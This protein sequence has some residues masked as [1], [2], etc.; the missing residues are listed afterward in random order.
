MRI[1]HFCWELKKKL[2]KKYFKNEQQVKQ[3]WQLMNT[4]NLLCRTIQ[5]QQCDNLYWGCMWAEGIQLKSKEKDATSIYNELKLKKWL[6]GK[7]CC[8]WVEQNVTY[9]CSDALSTLRDLGEGIIDGGDIGDDWL[10][11][12]RWNINIW[13]E[14]RQEIRK[15]ELKTWW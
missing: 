10:L 2:I 15:R 3:H 14:R 6:H 9:V 7:T 12:W 8:K 13:R 1:I 11:I 5:K 4:N